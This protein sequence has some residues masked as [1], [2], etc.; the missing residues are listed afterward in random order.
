MRETHV[1]VVPP[2]GAHAQ[3]L[4]K[5]GGPLGLLTILFGLFV[6][7]NSFASLTISEAPAPA[8]RILL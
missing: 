8:A 2:L 1:A 7:L 3:E 5:A 6:F 4:K